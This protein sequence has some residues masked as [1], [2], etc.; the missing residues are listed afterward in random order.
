MNRPWP[1]TILMNILLITIDPSSAEGRRYR[2]RP[3][4]EHQTEPPKVQMR[5]RTKEKVSKEGKIRGN[6]HP[7]MDGDTD[8]EPHWSTG[9]RP[10]R[11]K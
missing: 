1:I 3:T 6:F 5:S 9:L 4:L 11:S 10:P 7:T 2:W 8:G